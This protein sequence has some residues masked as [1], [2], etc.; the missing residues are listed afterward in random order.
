MIQVYPVAGDELRE[1][2]RLLEDFLRNGEPTSDEF[3]AEFR[4]AVEAGELEILAARMGDEVVG[5][6][7]LAWRL[8]VSVGGRFASVEEL[9][10]I[11]EARRRGVGR[12]LLKAA[13]E[14]CSARGA[15]YVEVEVMEDT[16]EAFY[17]DLGFETEVD[18]KVMSRSY[19]MRD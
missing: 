3:L 11:P 14:R 13:E 18:V 6:L 8:N 2:L 1:P 5:V 4:S 15:S 10:V 19:P 9:Y 17:E 16:V 7:V 12:N